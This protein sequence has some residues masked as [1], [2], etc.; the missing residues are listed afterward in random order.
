MRTLTAHDIIRIWETGRAQP[1]A[2]RAITV[3][4][5]V[6]PDETP[7]MLAELSIGER[8]GRLLAIREES[9]GTT[10]D[11]TT[12]CPECHEELEFAIDVASI[13]QS[14][15]DNNTATFNL[16]AGS[17][18]IACR[19][20]NS[21]DLLAIAGCVDEWSARTALVHRCTQASADVVSALDADEFESLAT[22]LARE[23]GQR[24]PQADIEL[25]TACAACGY[26]WNVIFDIAQYLW[27]EIGTRAR[28]LL[29]EVHLVASAY[30]WSEAEILALPDRR[31]RA[32][33]E[34][35]A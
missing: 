32:Y 8:D 23:V 9:F 15:R 10:I 11:A 7:A 4:S 2:A 24:D 1:A 27:A 28:R 18:D 35:I 31:R 22:A 21:S 14:T 26:E 3:L 20:P 19:L 17:T 29:N 5:A 16:R 33:V 25:A 34:M 13:R 6:L 12:S 30:G